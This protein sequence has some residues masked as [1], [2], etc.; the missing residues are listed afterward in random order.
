MIVGVLDIRDYTREGKCLKIAATHLD[1]R[2]KT[3]IESATAGCFDHIDLSAEHGVSGE[4]PSTA[5][6]RPDFALLKAADRPVMVVPEI[7]AVP[8]GQAGN[9]FVTGARF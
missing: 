7:F 6:W 1:D 8:V 9:H 4:D 2:T 5:F 3:A